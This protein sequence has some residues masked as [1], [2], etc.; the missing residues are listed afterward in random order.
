[1]L[2]VDDFQGAV[3]NDETIC[4]TETG[5]YPAGEVYTL[6]DH[7]NRIG[8]G[9]LSSLHLFENIGGIAGGAVVH[10]LIEPG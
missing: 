9:L 4:G 3:C 2:V 7:D 8:A 1:M 10:F 6:L 5:R